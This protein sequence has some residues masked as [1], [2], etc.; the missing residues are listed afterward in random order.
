MEISH[1]IEPERQGLWIAAGFIVALLALVVGAVAIYRINVVMVAT[2]TEVL[3]LSNKIEE[4][5]SGQ[6]TQGA[7]TPQQAA[8]AAAPTPAPAA[9][10]K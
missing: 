5:K 7:A 4:L 6:G 3:F 2:Q 1:I 8:P 9:P 10:T